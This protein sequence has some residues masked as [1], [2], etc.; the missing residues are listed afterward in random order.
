MAEEISRDKEAPHSQL[1]SDKG[2]DKRTKTMAEEISRD[3]AAPHSQLSSD[4]GKEKMALKQ[5]AL[6]ERRMEEEQIEQVNMAQNSDSKRAMFA[7][8]WSVQEELDLLHFFERYKRKRAPEFKLH[9]KHSMDALLEYMK[10]KSPHLSQKYEKQQIFH[11]LRNIRRKYMKKMLGEGPSRN[12]PSELE[13]YELSRKIWFEE[14]ESKNENDKEKD[15][16]SEK[17]VS[18]LTRVVENENEKRFPCLTKAVE[19]CS[20]GFPYVFQG[21]KM[22]D[23]IDPLK[24]EKLEKEWAKFQNH[25]LSHW[26]L[27]TR[28][29]MDLLI[30]TAKKSDRKKRSILM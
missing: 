13:L 5:E 3:K 28:K 30:N 10:K 17:K 27:L 9:G 21:S 4:K 16:E 29:T 22:V 25:A 24:A 8:I 20:S 26:T 19:Q 6:A 23:M 7:R 14:K 12:D 18:C 1:S 2:K 15:N 11:K